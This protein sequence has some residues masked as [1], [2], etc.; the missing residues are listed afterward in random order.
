MLALFLKNCIPQY[1]KLT[2]E[3]PKDLEKEKESIIDEKSEIE[4]FFQS[5]EKNCMEAEK[6]RKQE[7][8]SNTTLKIHKKAINN[9]N[10]FVLYKSIEGSLMNNLKNVVY[11]ISRESGNA[12]SKLFYLVDPLEMYQS[13]GKILH[14]VDE[15]MFDFDMKV[16]E[17]LVKIKYNLKKKELPFKSLY[18]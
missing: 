12:S 7:E 10:E 18:K 17:C 9:S 2:I 14:I 4:E 5:L 3:R 11:N 13:L 8:E 16:T 6:R 15:K 1:N